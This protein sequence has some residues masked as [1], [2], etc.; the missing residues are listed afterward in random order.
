[1]NQTKKSKKEKSDQ[2][3]EVIINILSERE[4]ELNCLYKVEEALKN[5]DIDNE[6]IFHKL[7]EIVPTGWQFVDICEA[8]IIFGNNEYTRDNFK[9]TR[10]FQSSD[11][12]INKKPVGKIQ[13]YYTEKISIKNGNQFLPE[14]IKLLDTI[15]ERVSQFIFH[16]TLK[17][18]I[19]GL[20]NAKRD[21]DQNKKAE[22][23]VIVD[24]LKRPDHDLF[25]KITRRML[26][27]LCWSGSEQA[28]KLLES[29]SVEKSRENR[30]NCFPNKPIERKNTESYNSICEKTFEVASKF[31]ND[32]DILNNIQ[33]WIKEDKISFLVKTL[34]N[35]NTSNSDILDAITKYFHTD[36][37]KI[38]F[39]ESAKMNTTVMILHRFFSEQIKFVNIAKN[40]FDIKDFY[41]ILQHT[42]FP[43]NSRGKLGGKS[44]GLFL[45][46]NIIHKIPELDEDLKKQVKTPK[47]WYVT[48]DALIHFL[49]YN[50]LEDVID[51]KYKE[52]SQIRE[53][54]PNIV[55]VFKNSYFPPDIIKGLSLTLDDFGE[56][57]IIVRSSSLLEDRHGS[58]FSGKYKSLFLAN[59]GEKE[60]RLNALMDA[61]AE[62]YAST[63]GP[64][65]IE[66]RKERDLLDFYEEMAVMIQEVVGKNVGKYFFPAFAGVGFSSNEF[67]WS[68]RIQRDDGLLRIV[69]GLGTRAVDR[70]SNDFPILIAPGKPKIKVN[71]TVD[72]IFRYSPK[73]MDVIN[74]ETNTFETVE[75]NDL[76]RSYGNDYP[77]IDKL[78]SVIQEDRV[79]NKSIL[80]MDFKNDDI[81]FSLNKL[82]ANT[83][84]IKDMKLILEK[85]EEHIKAPV[86]IEFA[87]D[88]EDF[89]LLQCRPQGYSGETSPSSI[90]KDIPEKNIVFTARKYISNGRIP[91]ITHIV[92]VKPEKYAE[93]TS[94]DELR[95][96]GK[97]V[98]KLNSILPKR[99]FIL[100]GPGRWGSR[101]DIKLGVNV[102]YSDI[103]N[104]SVLIEVAREKGNYV[105]DLSFGTHFFQDLV[106]ASIRYI[107]LYPDDDDIIYN[108]IFLN[109]S[110]NILS[111]LVP[112]FSY[113]EDII[114]VIDV[115]KEAKGRILRILMNA[116]LD[117]A[118]AYLG[119]PSDKYEIKGREESFIET[120]TENHWM[121]RL[122]MAKHIA[123]YI[124]PKH[125]GIEAMYIFG[126][127]KNAIAGPASDIDLL[128]HFNGNDEQKKDVKS[129]FDGWSLCLSEINY[130]KTGYQTDGLLDVHFITDE[131]IK[132]K[133][134]YAIKIKAVTDAARPLKMKKN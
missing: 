46:N 92:Y 30:D 5:F 32:E 41:N 115:Q 68:H 50:N 66:Y 54:Y 101:G 17:N 70:L 106:E 76:L 7:L 12:L 99:K 112:E 21:I 130:L 1:M 73:N 42:I 62:V 129:W 91:D 27:F 48:S 26:N 85:L 43:T 102:T 14:E 84:F 65:P 51:Q 94:L 3:N 95:V 64:D 25:Q 67:R 61:I 53:E 31:L 44:S 133:N 60:D 15:A 108:E 123:E 28:K 6:E 87:H 63:F 2:I 47:T 59:Q 78:V 117:E 100:M 124:D 10:W 93:L 134:S 111:E 52:I 58:A 11:I 37:E 34:E 20:E 16:K 79:T 38:E 75:I 132:N 40:Y 35:R 116:D 131:D 24:L 127:T 110:K 83:S 18:E 126:S 89:Y 122:R 104:T 81:V 22:W 119:S 109:R 74:L 128:V 98:G 107:P 103:N 82:V 80:N 8:K 45:A 56:K 9:K 36:E 55:Q 23:R 39:S 96:I 114:T 90:P 33:N 88:G 69:P 72:E 49:Y 113:L 77:I 13:V 97:V 57:P 4:K 71:I 125:F 118:I 29:Y 105:P 86:D 19:E 120:Q 121:W